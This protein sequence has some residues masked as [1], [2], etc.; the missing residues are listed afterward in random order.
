MV[1]YV[2]NKLTHIERIREL[3]GNNKLQRIY[4]SDQMDYMFRSFE[5][6]KKIA[7]D[8]MRDNSGSRNDDLVSY[9][10]LEKFEKEM[11]E[12]V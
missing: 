11:S 5:V 7:S 1:T 9:F 3:Q 10:L 8:L 12:Y 2:E 6:M 4:S